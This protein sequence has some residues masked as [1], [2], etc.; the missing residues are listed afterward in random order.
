M[1]DILL[2]ANGLKEPP[3][4]A[5]KQLKKYLRE[6]RYIRVHQASKLAESSAELLAAYDAVIFYFSE[7]DTQLSEKI[8]KSLKKYIKRGGGL[9]IL[10]SASASFRQN[11]VYRSLIGA[12]FISSSRI[13]DCTL[14]PSSAAFKGFSNFPA[15]A[16]KDELLKL[17]ISED[18]VLQM[19]AEAED[20][21]PV[22]AVWTREHGDGRVCCVTPGHSPE[23]FK[24]SEIRRLL[25]AAI[26]YVL[27]RD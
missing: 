14:R 5:I 19:T 26:S 22:P 18:S 11:H 25:S 27:K 3:I 8:E 23:T 1:S 16:V 15:F 2:V 17:E 13:T 24:N 7:P 12:E 9:L 21:G 20:G 4:Q 6:I 10:H